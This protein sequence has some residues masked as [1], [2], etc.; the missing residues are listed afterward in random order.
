MA[1]INLNSKKTIIYDGYCT[2]CNSSVSF[3]QRADK[4]Q[5]FEFLSRYSDEAKKYKA[6][7]IDSIILVDG[8]LIYYKSQAV[9]KIASELGY[10]YKLAFIFKVF[11]RNWLNVIYDFVARNRHKWFKSKNTCK[12][13]Y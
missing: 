7:E 6:T 12:L 9:L 13:H 10:P 5:K 1:E 8:D 11:P 2:M 4:K 3:I